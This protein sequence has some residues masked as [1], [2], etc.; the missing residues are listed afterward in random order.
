MITRRQLRRVHR[1]NLP[2]HIL[3]QDYIQAIFLRELYQE[4]DLLVSKGGTFLRQAHG[5]D[6][7][8]Q[9]LDF[10]LNGET[11]LDGKLTMAAS[12]LES[13]GIEAWLDSERNTKLSRTARLRYKGPLYNGSEKSLGTV[14]I[15]ISKRNDV[16][17]E[18]QWVRMFF[19][20]PEIRVVNV[21]ALQKKELLAEKLR[22]LTMRAKGRDL[23]DVWFL[24]RQDV[25]LDAIL[26]ERKMEVVDRPPTISLSVPES[27]WERDLEVLLPDPPKYSLV[28]QEVTKALE[29]KGYQINRFGKD[30]DLPTWQEEEDRSK[31]REE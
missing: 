22:A 12:N 4:V 10:T 18:P 26:F 21:L 25:E 9:D 31:F 1:A 6:R 3:E 23:Y 7:F 27:E 13:Y 5:L 15:E 28:I 8:S 11:D 24:I 17:L 2:L 19:K 29:N 14:N 20:Y 16:F 30:P